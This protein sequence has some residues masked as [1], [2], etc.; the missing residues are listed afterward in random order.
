MHKRFDCTRKTGVRNTANGQR[1]SLLNEE[2][3]YN[4]HDY[5]GTTLP[6][7]LQG[8]FAPHTVFFFLSHTPHLRLSNWELS[9]FFKRPITFYFHLNLFTRVNV[10]LRFS[11]KAIPRSI[12]AVCGPVSLITL[13]KMV[14]ISAHIVSS[15]FCGP[16]Y[17]FSTRYFATCN[18]SMFLY[19]FPLFLISYSSQFPFNISAISVFWTSA[20]SIYGIVS[21]PTSS[22]T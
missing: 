8:C 19:V 7:A 15:L 16:F 12:N 22:A 14:S 1:P 10:M 20:R 11:N 6:M 3:I 18:T 4:P 2:S 9:R 13:Q 5:R 21:F 17:D